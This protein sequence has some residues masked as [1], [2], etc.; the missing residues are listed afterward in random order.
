[1]VCSHGRLA[2][3]RGN[4]QAGGLAIIDR[5]LEPARGPC[6]AA[7]PPLLSLARSLCLYSQHACSVMSFLATSIRPYLPVRTVYCHISMLTS[8]R[9]HHT[10]LLHWR[11]SS[12]N[13]CWQHRSCS[14][15]VVL[16]PAT[17]QRRCCMCAAV[18]LVSTC[19]SHQPPLSVVQVL[20]ALHMLMR[21]YI[22]PSGP[23]LPHPPTPIISC[24]RADCIIHH[25]PI[26]S[27]LRAGCIEPRSKI[28]AQGCTTS[29]HPTQRC[30]L[31]ARLL[32][33]HTLAVHLP[34]MCYCCRKV[35]MC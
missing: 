20:A 31:S 4:G 6:Q 28:T 15:A 11:R 14:L 1:V 25:T 33:T 9:G 30:P 32:Q 2:R 10:P 23:T 35:I 8:P 7:P 12:S 29:T 18:G 26:T 5:D 22:N 13:P 34:S 21:C 19:A 24:L 3:C 27:C 17:P 16:V